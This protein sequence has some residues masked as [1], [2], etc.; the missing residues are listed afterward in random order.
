MVCCFGNNADAKKCDL[1]VGLRLETGTLL[2]RSPSSVG[3]LATSDKARNLV[4]NS[5]L[6]AVLGRVVGM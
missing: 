4:C 5:H 2:S 6:L 1:D 3:G